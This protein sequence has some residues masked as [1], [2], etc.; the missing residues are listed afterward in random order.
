MSKKTIHHFKGILLDLDHTLYDYD[1]CHKAGMNQVFDWLQKSFSV[2]RED[3]DKA[4]TTARKHVNVSLAETASSHNRI[5]YFQK[6]LELLKLPSLQYS[7]DAY[8]HYWDTFLN[9]IRFDEGVEETLKFFRSQNKKVC[10]VTDLTAH[11][12]HRKILKLKLYEYLDFMVSSEEA[13]REKPDAVMFTLGVQK[14]ELKIEEVCM[15]GDNYEKDAMGASRLGIYTYWLNRDHKNSAG[16]E[17]VKEIKTFKELLV[18][19]S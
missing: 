19:N 9:T 7:L 11:I 16:S 18:L 17:F 14:L 5:L 4:F 3:A 2:A 15:I 10:L 8:N 12:Q 6:M 13:G 1:P